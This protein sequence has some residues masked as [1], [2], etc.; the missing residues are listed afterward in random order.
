VPLLLLHT[1][2]VQACCC[3]VLLLLLLLL[4][5]PLQRIQTLLHPLLLSL[6][7]LL[8]TPIPVHT[9]F[10]ARSPAPQPAVAAA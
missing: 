4:L 2:A 8:L 9:Q 1:P 5:L 6:L 7:P 10:P 3:Q